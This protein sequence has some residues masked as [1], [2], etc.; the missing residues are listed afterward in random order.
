M[1]DKEFVFNRNNY[2]AYYSNDGYEQGYTKEYDNE[3]DKL[4]DEVYF[5]VLDIDEKEKEIKFLNN[6]IRILKARLKKIPMKLIEE[7]FVLIVM[8]LI[9]RFVMAGNSMG[10]IRDILNGIFLCILAFGVVKVIY[11]GIYDMKPDK[12]IRISILIKHHPLISQIEE[13]ERLVEIYERTIIEEKVKIQKLRERIAV[14]EAEE[15]TNVK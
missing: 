12:V 13:K 1:L 7:I 4:R 6:D 14:L 15:N 10:D 11:Q 5:Y 9:Y 8:T 2:N 3:I